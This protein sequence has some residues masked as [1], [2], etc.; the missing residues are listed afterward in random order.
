MRRLI[1]FILDYYLFNGAIEEAL[2][3]AYAKGFVRGLEERNTLWV[4]LDD[5][6]VGGTDC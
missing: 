2:Y 5:L 6:K 1:L 3:E 4:D